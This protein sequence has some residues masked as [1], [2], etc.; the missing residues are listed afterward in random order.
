VSHAPR[1]VFH[2]ML[3]AVDRSQR[4]NA[5]GDHAQVSEWGEI[6]VL[7]RVHLRCI[8]GA[9]ADVIEGPTVCLGAEQAWRDG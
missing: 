1:V 2:S 8:A 7:L 6:A 9:Y 5:D 3:A 4:L